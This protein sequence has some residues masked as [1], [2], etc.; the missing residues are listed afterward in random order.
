MVIF[1]TPNMIP[2]WSSAEQRNTGDTKTRRWIFRE[3]RRQSKPVN[4]PLCGPSWDLRKTKEII[5][6]SST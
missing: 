1:W 3:R 6:G 2:G 5:D 4:G